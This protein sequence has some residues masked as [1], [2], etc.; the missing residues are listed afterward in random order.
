MVKLILSKEL[1]ES[2]VFRNSLMSFIT[3]PNYYGHSFR[4]T[5]KAASQKSNIAEFFFN[6]AMW[7][8]KQKYLI[9]IK[10]WFIDRTSKILR[11]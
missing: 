1:K 6:L 8:E 7:A 11:L 4:Q 10:P 2:S 3:L 5:V 9:W